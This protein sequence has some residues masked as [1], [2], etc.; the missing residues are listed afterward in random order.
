M[1]ADENIFISP[2]S[3]AAVLSSVTIGAKGKTSTQVKSGIRINGLSDDQLIEEMGKLLQQIGKVI[4]Q[5]VKVLFKKF[6]CIIIPGR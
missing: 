6:N 2:P 1:G 4:N 3:V 5:L